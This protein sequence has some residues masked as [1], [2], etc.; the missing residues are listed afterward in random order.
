MIPAATQETL[1]LPAY[2]WTQAAATS[3]AR[4][5]AWGFCSL[6]VRGREHLPAKEPCLLCANHASHADTFALATAA[7]EA[8]RRLVFLGARDYFS[9]LRWRRQLLERIICLVDFDRRSTAGATLHNLRALGACRDAGR[10]VVLFP[11]GTRSV[12]GQL[13]RFKPGAA[14][15]ADKLGLKVIPCRIDGAHAILRKG[16]WLPRPVPLRV[17]FGPAQMLAPG[18]AGETGAERGRRYES[19]M[20]HIQEQVARLRPDAAAAP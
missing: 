15:F 6:E 7:G 4:G 12:D 20:A 19:F 9:R 17:T 18:P 16:D 3:L 10:I 14:M 11:E 5:L 2:G 13:G 1:K 8:S